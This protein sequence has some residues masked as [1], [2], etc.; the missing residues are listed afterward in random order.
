MNLMI[1]KL[2]YSCSIQGLKMWAHC[3]NQTG[4]I[5]CGKTEFAL[6]FWVCMGEIRKNN[7]SF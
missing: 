1:S 2:S 7:L 6:R 4:G 3:W 5:V